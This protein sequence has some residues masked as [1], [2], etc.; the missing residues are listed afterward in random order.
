MKLPTAR[1]EEA[2]AEKD[3]RYYLNG[4]YV[5]AERGR[6]VATDGHILACHVHEPNGQK[7]AI[8]PI[9]VV[10]AARVG[11]RKATLEIRAVTEEHTNQPMF[12]ATNGRTGAVLRNQPIDGKFPEYQRVIPE[13]P[14]GEPTITLNAELLVRLQRALSEKPASESGVKL[15][16]TDDKHAA[17]YVETTDHAETGAVGVIMPMRN[18]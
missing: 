18:K 3:I 5:D 15:W 9:D 7:S 6:L 11:G 17:I 10:K 12:E 16:I 13:K 2:A 14:A 1:I 4:V 8:V